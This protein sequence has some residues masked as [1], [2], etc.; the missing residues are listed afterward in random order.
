MQAGL[1][2]A[3]RFSRSH[4]ATSAGSSSRCVAANRGAQHVQIV[5][6][7]EQILHPLQILGPDFVALRQKILDHVA[8]MLDADRAVGARPTLLRLLRAC[9]YSSTASLSCA[10][11]QPL[12][13]HA[14]ER[15]KMRLATSFARAVCASPCGR[16]RREP[17]RPACAAFSPGG[18]AAAAAACAADRRG[19]QL[20]DPGRA[21]TWV[22]RSRP[23]REKDLRLAF[24]SLRQPGRGIHFARARRP[25]C[26]SGAEPRA[27]RGR[28]RRPS[29]GCNLLGAFEHA[30]HP[31]FEADMVLADDCDRARRNCRG[32]GKSDLTRR[33]ARNCESTHGNRGR[34]QIFPA[35][36]SQRRACGG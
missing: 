3:L 13:H 12:K 11:R 18:K 17:F 10:K 20:L 23:V 31:H 30:V 28:R 8:E 6:V 29:C 25:W 36:R 34:G 16:N 9:W 32:H 24:F 5:H 19:A 33:G 2:L 1:A 21:A 35:G 4:C 22:S 15:E 7:A 26:G 27:D 14:F